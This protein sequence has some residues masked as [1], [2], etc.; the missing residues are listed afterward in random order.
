MKPDWK[1]APKWARWLTRRENGAW[2]WHE[3]PPFISRRGTLSA[4]TEGDASMDAGRVELASIEASLFPII[5][6]ERP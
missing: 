2:H 6:E 5:V 3:F 4:F 1:E